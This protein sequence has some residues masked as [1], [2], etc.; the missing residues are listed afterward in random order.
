MPVP[1]FIEYQGSRLQYHRFGHGNQWLFCFHG[2]GESGEKFLF[3]QDALMA[4]HTVIAIDMPFHGGTHWTGPLLLEPSVVMH[5]IQQLAPPG[6]PVQ[7]MGYSMGGRI[8]LR[9]LELY[10]EQISKLVLVA[11]D[12]LHKNPWQKLATRSWPGNQLFRF[13]M[14]Y[15]GWMFGMMKFLISLR[16]FNKSINRFA[17]HY[18]D[19]A[20]ERKRLYQRWTTMRKFRPSVSRLKKTIITYQVPVHLLFGKY[21]RVIL[22]K[23]GF[24]LQKGLEQQIS[25][26][27]LEAG[28]QLLQEKYKAHLLAMIKN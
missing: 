13:T 22:P 7:L 4:T 10:P 27:V 8:C 26:Q 20:E 25:M 5:I 15:P 6:H 1:L 18:L 2:Y 23:H 14:Q 11:P 3:L 12:G 28:H 21:D 9:L 17:H 16:L 19:D 24:R